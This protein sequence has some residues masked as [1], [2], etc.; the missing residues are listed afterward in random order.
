[1]LRMFDWLQRNETQSKQ[2]WQLMN[3]HTDTHALTHTDTHINSDLFSLFRWQLWGE[4]AVL[5]QLPLLT[6]P[7]LQTSAQSAC[8]PP[9]APSSSLLRHQGQT[10]APTSHCTKSPWL[11]LPEN[12]CPASCNGFDFASGLLWSYEVFDCALSVTMGSLQMN[13]SAK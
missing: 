7:P 6:T 5:F 1:M 12:V 8:S 9:S 2:L 13:R 4:I 10:H 3:T 11:W